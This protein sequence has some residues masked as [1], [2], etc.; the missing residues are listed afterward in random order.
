VI[1]VGVERTRAVWSGAMNQL[2]RRPLPHMTASEFLA[3][4]GDGSGRRFQL[5]D[6]EIRPMA[7]ASRI[8]GVIQANLAYLL[9]S[10]VRAKAL[11]LQIL[12][13]GAIIPAL[14]ASGNVRV[15][16]FVVAPGDDMRGDQVVTDPAAVVE[17]LSPGNS[18]ETRDNIRAYST[19]SS[20]REI[21]VIHTGRI[22]AELHRR[23]DTGAWQSDPELIESSERLQLTSIGLECLL[24]E[25]YANTWLTRAKDSPGAR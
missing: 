7:P 11:P 17:I 2:A 3:W 9:V 23:N 16:D 15:P 14:G 5:V 1:G 10:A 18:D 8:H 21:V 19:L 25:A 6:G 24:D 22:L 13:E 12:A 4:P 20:M